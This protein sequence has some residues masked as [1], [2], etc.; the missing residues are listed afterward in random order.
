MKNRLYRNQENRVMGGVC[1]GLGEFLGIDPIFIR[2]FFVIWVIL[3]ELAVL[4]YLVLWLVIPPKSAGEEGYPR[5]LGARF[6]MIGQEIGDVAR[7]PSAEL[8]T[9]AGAGL[10]AWG[11]FQLLRRIG[12]GWFIWDYNYYLWPVL[13]IIAGAFVLYRSFRDRN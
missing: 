8:I 7:Q 11:V 2:I 1:A 5:D 4:V 6:R 13:L 3:G 12:I 10:I 9:Y